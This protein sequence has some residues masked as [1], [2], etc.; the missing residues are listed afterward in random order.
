[1]QVKCKDNP[2]KARHDRNA[3]LSTVITSIGFCP[4][5]SGTWRQNRRDRHGHAGFMSFLAG[6][7]CLK[8]PSLRSVP[9]GRL[10]CIILHREDLLCQ[11]NSMVLIGIPRGFIIRICLIAPHIPSLSITTGKKFN[12]VRQTAS[13]YN[14]NDLIWFPAMFSLLRPNQIYLRSCRGQRSIWFAI[15]FY[16]K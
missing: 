5:K 3:P 15:L 16:A 4:T 13:F 7:N 2:A 12:S 6:N 8:A 11:G 1:M 10:F 14:R 9:R